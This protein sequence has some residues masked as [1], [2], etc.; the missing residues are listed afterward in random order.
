MGI[1]FWST[2]SNLEPTAAPNHAAIFYSWMDGSNS[3]L[4]IQNELNWPNGVTFDYKNLVLYWV[5]TSLNKLEKL[6]MSWSEDKTK[7][8]LIERKSVDADAKF[9]SGPYGLALHKDVLYW[10]EFMNGNINKYDLN[11]YQTER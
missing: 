11:T 8:N 2:W 5:D 4:L 3:S 6:H 9:I 10:T 7:L 1:M